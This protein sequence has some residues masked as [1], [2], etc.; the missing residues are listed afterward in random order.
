VTQISEHAAD[1][2]H[3]ESREAGFQVYD[4]NGNISRRAARVENF[5]VGKIAFGRVRLPIATAHN[6]AIDGLLAVNMMTNY[7]I[8]LDFP[9]NTMS[10]LSPGDCPGRGTEEKYAQD[11]VPIT[12]FNNRIIVKV[13]LDG[14]QF[15]ALLDTGST[16]SI[17]SDKIAKYLFRLPLGATGDR[18]IKN[19]NGD[20]SFTGYLHT[21]TSLS[22][23]GMTIDHPDFVILEDR[24]GR[25]GDRTAQIGN[26]ALAN[27]E[28]IALPKLI[29]GMNMLK[30][31]RL[32]LSFSERRLYVS[33]GVFTKKPRPHL[34]NPDAP[35][36]ASAVAPSP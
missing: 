34:S 17:M 24:M 8:D 7:D 2:M 27:K 31:L 5:Q 12:R 36:D 20:P 16:Q 22:F 15:D 9:R 25:N 33:E 1:E 19:I 14:Q 13:M 18:L 21:F 28:R 29:I 10:Y 30:D 4:V 26:R 35:P 6:E 11:V 32:Y 23:G 3:L